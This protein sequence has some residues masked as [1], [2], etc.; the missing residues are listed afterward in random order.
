MDL[1]DINCPFVLLIKDIM[2]VPKD[3]AKSN[4]LWTTTE[5]VF[6]VTSTKKGGKAHS[7]PAYREDGEECAD[8]VERN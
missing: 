5:S 3:V 1:L 2:E 7:S 6:R 8:V 4:Y